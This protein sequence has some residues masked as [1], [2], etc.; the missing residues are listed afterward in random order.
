MQNLVVFSGAGMS[1]ESGIQTFRDHDGLWENYNIEDV[2][3][4]EAWARNPQLVQD[5]YNQRR[6]H[7]LHAQPNRAHQLIAQ[8]QQH[9]H[10]NV[11]TQ[12]ID[13]LH[14]RAGNDNVL[15]LHG[16]IR[17]AKSSGPHAEYATEF[18]PIE[19]WELNL[20]TDRC[21]LG[22]PLRPH[23]VWFGEAVPAYAEAQKIVQHADIFIVIGS[24]LEVYPVAGLIHEIPLH[25]K[26]YY[27]D[28]KAHQQTM[29]PQ[30]QLIAQT[31]T[32]GMQQLFTLLTT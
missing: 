24:S 12:N 20:E 27:I 21:P 10:L 3:T 26:A 22:Y 16:N 23:V 4:P 25:C 1:A 11:I 15:H 6:K 29:P 31:A 9:Y 18:Y 5:F 8:L 28:P 7:I 17:F 30:Y 19:G 14:E 2:A 32:E 13:D